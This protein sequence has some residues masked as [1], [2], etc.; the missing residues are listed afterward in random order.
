MK[1]TVFFAGCVFS[2]ASLAE[3]KFSK[4]TV[5]I[6]SGGENYY[7]YYPE[8]QASGGQQR[9]NKVEP[10]GNTAV[11][12]Y[13]HGAKLE[14]A[15]GEDYVSY[16][17]LETPSGMKDVKFHLV[18]PVSFGAR[19]AKWKVGAKSGVFPKAKGNVKLCQASAGDF[20]AV[21]GAKKFSVLFP[22]SFCWSE[23]QDLREWNWQAFGISFT[24]PFNANK[25]IIVIPFG[26]DA[27][28]LPSVRSR[29]ESAFFAKNG[30]GGGAPK[31]AKA[32]TPGLSM[33]ING[34]GL[35]M[36]CGSMGEFDL[37][38][39]KLKIGGEDRSKPIESRMEGN[40]CRM[41]FKNGGELTATLEGNTIRYRLVKKPE[42]YGKPFQE[43]FVPMT[44]NQ[45]G[46]WYVDSKS[47]EFPLTKGSA[48]LFQGSTGSFAISGPDNAKLK[49]KFS[50]SPW[51]E[52]QDNREW[53][54][55]IFWNGFHLPDGLGEWTV[56]VSLDTSAF[57]RK[58]LVDK[59]GQVPRQFKGKIKDES[60]FVSLAKSEDA[61][62]RSLAY[63]EKMAKRKLAL[64]EYGGLK[65]YGAK[66]K[67]KKTGFFHCEKK[68]IKG[69]ERWILV[70]P[71]GNPFF[72]LGICCFA[73]GSDDATDVSGRED[74]FEWLPPH[75]E[76]FT[77]A[78][79]DRPGDWWNSRAV[80]FYRANAIRKYG[81]FDDG[82]M[83][84]RYIERTR[85]VGFN[86]IGAFSPIPRAARE[87]NF[88]YVG[89]VNVGNP[90]W[91][92]S[93]R[94]MFDPFDEKSKSEVKRGM[95]H[96][97]KD[98]D[99]PL[100]IGYFLANEQGL[101]DIPRA[102]PALDASWAA[103]RAFVKSLK[104][105]YGT[106]EKFNRAWE[107]SES[108]FTALE[109]KGL[110]VTT[111]AAFADVNA[112]KEKFLEEYYSLIN[113]EFRANDPNHMLIGNRWQ[114]GT[115]NDEILCRV[116][117]KYMDVISINYY[118]AAIDRKFITRLYNWTGGK[119]QFWSE[120]YYTAT[121]ESNCGPSA[122][123]LATQKERGMAYRNYVQA[124]A[125][126]GFVT[127]V[128]WFTL[129][130][131]AATG[132]FFEGHNGERGNTGLFDVLDRPY[133][134]MFAEML[135]AHLDIYHVY[136]GAKSAWRFNDPRYNG[137]GG[138][139][140]SY[141][142]GRPVAAMAV[143]G[144]QDGF[145]L[146]PPERISSSRL[147]MGRDAEGLEA[148]FK[149][150]WD[151]KNL[152]LLVSVSDSSPQSNKNRGEWIWDGDG[153]EIFLGAESVDK[154][155]PMLFS[156]RQVLVSAS[157]GE[158]YV[159]KNVKGIKVKA[160]AVGRVDGKGHD[161]EVAVPWKLIDYTPK[162]GDEILFDLAVDDAPTGGKRVR[163][164][165]WNGSARNSS[166]RSAWGRLTLVP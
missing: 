159:P 18:M 100:M 103:K 94:G 91:I 155:G 62:Y 126:L 163:Q 99:D 33:S 3:V 83:A 120:F 68:T 20:T 2:L 27:S 123:D 88:P 39:P 49:L 74:A 14:L 95:K 31:S 1:A 133:K 4:E 38:H 92:P 24:T 70:D 109:S 116:A 43:M 114:P 147:V 122:Y 15:I 93:V 85:S 61:Y 34:W 115:A 124:A 158:V 143:D 67:L 82:E 162:A 80:S 17:L 73:A 11:C 149:G 25:R 150:A 22:E 77:A 140:R 46:K 86:S 154:G 125:E 28:K 87:A 55:S 48:K 113:R 23:L 6:K 129:I 107:A 136:F 36:S 156:D 32:A 165:M 7:L 142:I 128:E 10:A 104:A 63:G 54:W 151:D 66:M 101:E 40:T 21:V 69:K 97:A 105:K 76:K 60:E 112:F 5:D 30:S 138:A 65:G 135:E 134:D 118:A 157:T 127:G 117:G 139:T 146:R 56:S 72:H 110:A 141:S 106:I 90:R 57:A 144:K 111:K 9:P 35:K 16:R 161:I 121:R 8:V 59:F 84:G 13:A 64:D 119:P 47:G 132:R 44:F 153:I 102:I 53:G 12:S 19:G 145:P 81:K 51:M 78:W 58:V 166:D 130:D 98:A 148:S 71:A 164:L 137:D 75:D 41:K 45:G 52:V 26:P 96:M 42:G 37:A 29:V 131:Q 89:F 108:D 160:R 79:K 152:Y 50:A